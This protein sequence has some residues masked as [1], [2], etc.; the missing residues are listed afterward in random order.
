M[1]KKQKYYLNILVRIFKNRHVVEMFE[2][3]ID[4]IRQKEKAYTFA[5]KHMTELL[6]KEGA[7]TTVFGLEH[8]PYGQILCFASNH[9]DEF[10]IPLLVTAIPTPVGF[11]AKQEI[12]KI[13]VLS[14]WMK[15][16]HCVF[17]DLN[18]KEAAKKSIRDAVDQIETY[19]SF[20]I[21]PEGRRSFGGPIAPF[22]KGGLA[23]FIEKGIPIVPV[24]INR[25]AEVWSKENVELTVQF[26]PALSTKGRG[27]AEVVAEVEHI[28][29]S[30]FPVDSID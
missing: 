23:A 12:A 26:H 16:L 14:N 9:Q 11:I 20:V 21:F 18:N 13:P 28:V 7:K 19:G 30:G 2:D 1:F 17:I 8:I 4:P 10:D 5:K 24:T 6:V 22:K 29:R 15:Y 3:E 27:V 25:T